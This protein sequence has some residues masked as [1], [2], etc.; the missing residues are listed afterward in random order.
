MRKPKSKTV[1]TTPGWLREFIALGESHIDAYSEVGARKKERFHQ[2]GAH[3]CKEIAAK[4]GL[5]PGTYDIRSNKAGIAVCGEVTLHGE[6]LYLQF[7]QSIT[8]LGFMYRRC[9]GRK[10]YGGKG[11]RNCWMKYEKLLEMAW[12]VAALKTVAGGYREEEI[13][14]AGAPWAHASISYDRH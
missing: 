8:G 10:D 3:L 2:I 1:D 7:G 13:L 12:V 5:A 6:S 4:L 9:E 11:G 14:P